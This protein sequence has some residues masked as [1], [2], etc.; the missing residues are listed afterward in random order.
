MRGNDDKKKEK[1]KLVSERLQV[2]RMPDD[3]T[4]WNLKPG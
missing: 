4:S 1:N 2:A 3:K